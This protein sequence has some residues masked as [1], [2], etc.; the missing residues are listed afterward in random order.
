LGW[1]LSICTIPEKLPLIAG[2]TDAYSVCLEDS[3]RLELVVSEAFTEDA[4]NLAI[5]PMPL[6]ATASFS[7]N[8]AAPGDTV[9]M[10]LHEFSNSGN[11]LL[12]LIASDGLTSGLIP[13]NLEVK[14]I[15]TP[16]TLQAPAAD[17]S[18][19][20]PN[21][22]FSWS[23]SDNAIYRLEI[24]TDPEFNNILTTTETA[25]T[26]YTLELPE[27]EGAF[28][29]RVIAV[30]DCGE[31][32]SSIFSFIFTPSAVSD[33]RDGQQAKV[34]PNPFSNH[35]LLT[36]TQALKAPVQLRV[37]NVN[38]QVQFSGEIRAGSIRHELSLDRLSPG[39]YLLELKY[40]GQRH[41]QKLI[42]VL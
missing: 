17:A 9:F 2:L 8:P 13:F 34:Y 6:G 31:R 1:E 5:D 20:T 19:S 39:I 38:G 7:K 28:F 36:F 42:K 12:E 33:F 3:L 25:S 27:Q 32:I 16:V 30:N 14:D 40:L 10:V 18:L 23:P 15:P 24:A 26:F 11:Y 22:T 4:V 41:L 35:L 21:T 37:M 29:W